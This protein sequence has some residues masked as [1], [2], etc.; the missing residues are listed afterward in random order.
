[1]TD[2]LTL[3]ANAPHETKEYHL[4]RGKEVVKWP[5]RGKIKS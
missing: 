2:Q 4:K 5:N 3:M 1:M